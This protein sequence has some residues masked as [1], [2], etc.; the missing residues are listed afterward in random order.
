[1]AAAAEKQALSAAMLAVY[2]QARVRTAEKGLHVRTAR[3]SERPAYAHFDML[4]ERALFQNAKQ[5]FPNRTRNA[6]GR[7]RGINALEQGNR[8]YTSSLILNTPTYLMQ[9]V[10]LE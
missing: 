8:T 4:C 10:L 6:P 2:Q 3:V 9:Y 1:V 5:G 7:Q